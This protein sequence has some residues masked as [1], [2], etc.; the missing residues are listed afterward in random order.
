MTSQWVRCCPPRRNQ[1]RIVGSTVKGIY[2]AENSDTYTEYDRVK[3]EWLSDHQQ[4]L[5]GPYLGF[6]MDMMYPVNVLDDTRVRTQGLGRNLGEEIQWLDES[7]LVFSV[8]LY[9]KE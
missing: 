6:G 8:T 1:S 2:R 7:R 4:L 9:V 5:A 3:V